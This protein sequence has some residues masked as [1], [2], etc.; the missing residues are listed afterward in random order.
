[1]A[2]DN[3]TA[4]RVLRN[5]VV[6]RKNY[7]GSGSVWSA[8]LAA[9]MFSLLQTV[10]LWDLNPHHWLSAFL[11]ACAESGGKSPTALSSFLPWKMTPERR[12]DLARPVSVTLPPVFN[13]S[14]EMGEPAG[15][16]TS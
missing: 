3:N 7:Y 10:L 9:M 16:D 12:E 1:V 14:Q 8:H 5:P 4:E 2:L 15:V 11:Q 13:A 6:G